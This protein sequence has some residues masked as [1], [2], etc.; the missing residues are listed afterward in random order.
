[1]SRSQQPKQFQPIDADSTITFFQTTVQRHRGDLFHD[2]LVSVSTAH[3]A[4][5]RR[6]LRDVQRNARI[7]A[8]PVARNTGPA[9]LAAAL[10]ASRTDPDALILICPSDHVISGD[11]NGRVRES[12]KAANDGLI[13]TFQVTVFSILAAVVIGLLAGLGQ[14]SRNKILQ[15]ISTVYVEVIRGIPLVVQIFCEFIKVHFFLQK[16]ML[17]SKVVL[18]HEH[19]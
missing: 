9:V 4:T 16:L 19:A 8:E 12:M 14:I 3:L 10:L 18:S 17:C 1:L 5:V 11:L 6:Q 2:P 7:I 15:R 13:V